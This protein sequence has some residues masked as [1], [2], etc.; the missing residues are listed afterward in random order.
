MSGFDTEKSA[1]GAADLEDMTEY[2]EKFEGRK[3]L[4]TLTKKTEVKNA[5]CS[6][7][8][9]YTD[10]GLADLKAE[11][12]RVTASAKAK[13]IPLD[14]VFFSSPSPGTLANFF[15]DDY[16]RDHTKYVEALGKAMQREYDAIYASGLTLQVDC[17]DL[18]M[19]RHTKFKDKT[20]AEFQEAARTAVRVMNEAVADIPGERMRMH[21]C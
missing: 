10:D 11:I 4:L 13:G 15:D 1:V 20:L 17:P 8:I 21:V 9:S 14:K 7:P 16:F 3:G 2:S 18:A 6:G 19:G 12:D 5:A